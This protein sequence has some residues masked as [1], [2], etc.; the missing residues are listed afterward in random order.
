MPMQ[1][2]VTRALGRAGAAEGD[3]IREQRLKQLTVSGLVGARHDVAGGG[4][5]CGAVQI[6]PD[7]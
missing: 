4:A 1:L 3:A 6:Q 7:A 2:G 5:H